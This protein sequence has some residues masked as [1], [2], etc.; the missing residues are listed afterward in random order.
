MWSLATK[1]P[2]V[3]GDI[4]M[5]LAIRKIS[6]GKHPTWTGPW[7]SLFKP[8]THLLTF[9]SFLLWSSIAVRSPRACQAPGWAKDGS[10]LP[11]KVYS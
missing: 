8:N 9:P 6:W 11:Q 4:Q 3:P 7:P 1:S 5:T 10:R 2:C